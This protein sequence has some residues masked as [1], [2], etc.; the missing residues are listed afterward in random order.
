MI[1]GLL[2]LFLVMEEVLKTNLVGALIILK[3]FINISC[4]YT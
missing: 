4:H 1:L 2:T 3:F